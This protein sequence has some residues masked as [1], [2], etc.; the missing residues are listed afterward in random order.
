MST[1]LLD[2]NAGINPVGV[3]FN[4]DAADLCSFVTDYLCGINVNGVNTSRVFLSQHTN[5]GIR[6][7]ILYCFIK[8]NSDVFITGKNGRVPKHLAAKIEGGSSMRLTENAKRS[9]EHI[10]YDDRK[11]TVE[12][13]RALKNEVMI[14]LDIIKALCLYLKVTSAHVVRIIETAVTKNNRIIITAVKQEAGSIGGGNCNGDANQYERAMADANSRN[15]RHGSW[16]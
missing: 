8:K 3:V 1:N 6:E 13:S 7:A 12:K 15:S 5:K 11:I 2:T 4:I 10:T 16:D 14:E 9:L